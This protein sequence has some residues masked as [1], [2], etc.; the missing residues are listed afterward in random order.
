MTNV[1]S[2]LIDRCRNATIAEMV[3]FC[4]VVVR[5][6]QSGLGCCSRTSRSEVRYRTDEG[7]AG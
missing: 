6:A 1:A 2:R 4:V 5:G 3:T 7:H